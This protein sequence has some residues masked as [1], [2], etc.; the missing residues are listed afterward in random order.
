MLSPPLF[1]AMDNRGALPSQEAHGSLSNVHE[2]EMGRLPTERNCDEANIGQ[3]GAPVKEGAK[4]DAKP[5]G[6]ASAAGE[7]GE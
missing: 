7:M 1:P 6:A 4:L 5:A 2:D 3:L